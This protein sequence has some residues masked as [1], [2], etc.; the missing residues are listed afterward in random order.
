[1]SIYKQQ[2]TVKILLEFTDDE[3]S[4]LWPYDSVKAEAEIPKVPNGET[5]F[6]FTVLPD[7]LTKS[8]LLTA[9]TDENWPVGVYR[10]DIRFEKNGEFL[11][12]PE[13]S[14][15]ITFTITRPVTDD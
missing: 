4:N 11:F 5:E 7:E 3:W 6:L 10:A 14:E 1:M 9:A 2:S 15:F 13:G 8:I 12:Y